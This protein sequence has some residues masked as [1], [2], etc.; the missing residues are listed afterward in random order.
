MVNL[1]AL[2]RRSYDVVLVDSAPLIPVTDAAVLAPRADGVLV[3]VRHGRTTVQDVQAAK[4]A[5]HAVSGRILGS[6]MTMTPQTGT[7]A[8]ARLKPRRVKR[9][10]RPLPPRPAADPPAES[11]VAPT[12]VPAPE[13]QQ[14]DGRQ[15]S[16]APRPRP[17][18]GSDATEQVLDRS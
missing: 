7:L 18:E 2:L 14:Q 6:V 5:L 4:D 8:H 9:Q 15:P 1:I 11:A 3:V 13:P 12:T 17:A 16:P 10:L